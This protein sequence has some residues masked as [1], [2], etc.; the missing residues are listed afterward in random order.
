MKIEKCLADLQLEVIYNDKCIKCGSCGA[1]CPNI[2]FEEGNVKYKEQC[3]ETVGVCYNVCPRGS[4][5]IAELDQKI[6]GQKRENQAL[7]VYKKAV[8]AELKDNSLKD[9]TTALLVTAWDNGIIDSA[10]LPDAGVEKRLEPVICKSKDDILKNAGER[11]GFGPMVWGAGEAL[12]QGNK[13]VAV[14]GR[15]CHAQ[16]LGKILK[17][18]DFLVGQEK[19]HMVLSHFCLAQGKGCTICLDYVGEF[20]DIAIDPKTGDM[21]IKSDRGEALV[22]STVSAGKI[23]ISDIDASAI[24]EKALKKKTKNILKLIAKNGGNVEVNYAKL[25]ADNMKSLLS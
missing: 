5:N 15:P 11:K 19:I 9:I 18:S 7:G 8:K 16:G 3:S 12:N 23:S 21:L 14:V 6:F 4:L 1:F 24:E 10:V 25:D 22:N 2:Y 20:A 17:S 13:K